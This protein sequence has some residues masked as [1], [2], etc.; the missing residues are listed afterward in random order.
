MTSRIGPL[1]ERRSWPE[2]VFTVPAPD[3]LRATG[4][5]RLTLDL[6]IGEDLRPQSAL[7]CGPHRVGW[8]A[9]LRY[10]AIRATDAKGR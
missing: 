2:Q 4:P 5:R 6:A 1:P 3:A 9:A 10:G 8:I 7:L